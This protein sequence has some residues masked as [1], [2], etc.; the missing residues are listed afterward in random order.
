MNISMKNDLIEGPIFRSLVIFALP[1]FFSNIFQQLY[2]TVDT[3]IVGHFLGDSSLAAI[4]AC[5]SIYELMIGF[6][7]GVGSG[8]AIVT[9]R[10]YCDWNRCFFKYNIIGCCDFNAFITGF[11]YSSRDH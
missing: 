9:A 3:M 1:I 2:N 5:S 8:L 11:E 7:L 4:G 10:S 6:G